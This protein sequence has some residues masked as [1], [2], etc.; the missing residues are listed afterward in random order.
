M[1]RVL[2]GLLW[3][4]FSLIPIAL[5]GAVLGYVWLSRS[6][7]PDS[8]EIALAGL[9]APVTVTRDKNAVPHITG[10]SVE[11]VFTALGFVHAQ[12]RLWQMEVTRMAGQGRL[13]E[14]FGDKTIFTDR[15]LRSIGLYESS[16]ASAAALSPEDLKKI[17]AYTRGVND[18]IDSKSRPFASK[19]S[20]EFI[21]LGHT[22]EKWVAADVIVT[23][24]LMSVTLA[25]NVDDEILRLKLARLGMTD[26]ETT[27]LLPPLPGDTPPLLP[28]LRQILGL[29]T[30]A[31]KTGALEGEQ[32]Y[33]ALN[34]IMSS[35]ASNNWVVSG[36]RTQSGKPILAN[37]PHLGL[38]APS[39][40]YLAHL[41]V[42]SPDG[43][44]KNVVGVTTPGSPLVVL[45]R[46]DKIAWGFTNTDPD[47]QDI[48]LERVNPANAD[49][50][51]TPEG[52]KPFEKQSVE[53]K[54]KGADAVRFERLVT[55]HGPLLPANYRGL[56]HYLPDGVVAALSWTALANNDTTAS[57]GLKIWD[58][59]SVADF[60]NG[61]RDYVTPM[62]SMVVADV[63]GNIGLLA[64]GRVPVRDPANQIMG[65]APSPG[66][67]AT[68]D[69]KSFIPYEELPRF[70]NPAN[71][72][73]GTSNTKIVDAAYPHFLTYDWDEPWR[74]KRIEALI[75]NANQQTLET[76]SKVQGDSFSN[77][78]ANLGPAMLK[79]LEGRSD[80]DEDVLKR[81][82]AWD[83]VEDKARIEPLLFT[84]WV[85]MAMKRIFEDDLGDAFPSF[86][87]G[88]I[89]ALLRA[90]GPN[91]SR[92]WCDDGR[93]PIK[94]SCGDI[95]ALSLG[96][97]IKDI[98]TRLGSDRSK[99]NWGA[100]HYAYGAHRPF[101][102]VSPL[103]KIFNVT[104]PTSGGAFSLDRA[105]T[106]FSD[107][108]NPYRAT[109]GSSYRG[110]FDLADLERSTYI[111]TTGQS[112]N[113]FSSHYRDFADKW[114]NIEAIT[115]P[116]DEA[117][118]QDG[119]LGIWR[120]E[121]VK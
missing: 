92:N 11:D 39:L 40:W 38:S 18:F 113:V 43:K 108:S 56:D 84:G 116:T 69:W 71:G 31:I 112:G 110:L 22:P 106:T 7:A 3:I 12:E 53:I 6:V 28:D 33:A 41:Q 91:P 107:E 120:L 17:E 115:I 2:K 83:F 10:N 25:G 50:Y 70:F 64:P 101:A 30:D 96:D 81:L 78:Y 99:W 89:D 121:P 104:V 46:N 49:E 37:D 20:P 35:G 14:L 74:Q 100:L 75:Y 82:S 68:Y 51:Q 94:E 103:D 1:R 117:A 29:A 55:R 76:N 19:Y 80:V 26:A 21:I 44:T 72:A 32:Q 52:Y 42:K 66:W 98:E 5:L 61:M 77:G 15:F 45:G 79:L 23:L 93:T 87:S 36:T 58:F 47:V 109:H 65:R 114:A 48:F 60:Q 85:R 9:S 102:Q 62:Q 59:A 90:M 73:I 4:V 13:S 86:W 63:E 57:A 97:A 119:L 16:Q 118:Y 105:N 95:F 67:D 88:R 8:G 24:K 54:V 34:E 111:Q 27:D